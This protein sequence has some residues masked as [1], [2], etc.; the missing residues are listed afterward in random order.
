MILRR[1]HRGKI[2][3]EQS[4]RLRCVKLTDID[5]VRYRPVE[6]MTAIGEELRQVVPTLLCAKSRRR[7]GV[8]TAVRDSTD[9]SAQPRKQDDAVAAPRPAGTPRGIRQPPW[10]S[11]VDAN[12]FEL[13]VGKEP[14]GSAV[15]RPEREGGPVGFGE[16]TRGNRVEGTQPQARLA[17][18]G[19]HERQRLPVRRNRQRRGIGCRWRRD[20]NTHL[21]SSGTGA[22]GKYQ[23]SGQG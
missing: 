22:E 16:R 11:A 10:R 21:G 14:H 5:A 4:A 6:E 13:T 8:A 9:R 1:I 7:R 15:W 12:L 20:F 17:V 18:G 3:V 2:R 23:R 19:G